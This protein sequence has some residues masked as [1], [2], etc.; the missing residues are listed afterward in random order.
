MSPPS[1]SRSN[2]LK[3]FFIRLLGFLIVWPV[4]FFL[5][6][7][8]LAFWE[9]WAYLGILILPMLFAFF[10]WLK[11][12]PELLVRRMKMKEKESAQKRI[13]Q[14]FSICFVFIF[15]LPGFDKR[16]GWSS[17][18]F[19]VIIV[20]HIFL[21]IGYLL[22]LLA[23]K[24]NR[25][26]SRIVEVEKG[27]EVVT[28]GLYAIVRHPM[29]LGVLIMCLSSPTALDSY[30]ALIPA[31]PVIPLLVA[32]IRNE[33]NVLLRNLDGYEKYMQKTRFR[34]IPCIW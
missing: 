17:V 10:Y 11:T 32:R 34:L 6:A 28:T 9:A 3:M 13:I 29:Y 15:L 14:Y 25:Y 18:P 33:E 19:A 1:I 2:L 22:C 16:F 20:S 23:M 4:V 31:L 24:E 8:T 26:A 30:W 27:Q 7:G 5:P 12:D 21:F